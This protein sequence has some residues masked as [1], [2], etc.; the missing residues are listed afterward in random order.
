LKKRSF[1]TVGSEIS[2]SA[3]LPCMDY[4]HGDVVD[5]EFEAACYYEYAKESAFLREAARLWAS[6]KDSYKEIEKTA[7]VW[8]C[9]SFL[10]KSW[11]QLSLQE[12]ANILKGVQSSQIQPLRVIDVW[13]LDAMGI[14]DELETMAEEVM[15]SKRL[16]KPQRKVY[17]IIEGPIMG[18]PNQKSAWVHV[19]FTLDFGK[20][21]KR[22]LQEFD[23][24]LQLPEN[25]ARLDAHRQNPTGKTGEF[26]DRLKDLAAWRIYEGC[27]RDWEKADAFANDHRIN[28]RPFHD[29]RQGQTKKTP[30]NEA[31][32]YS[33]ES[34]FLKAKARALAY[35]TK[36]GIPRAFWKFTEDTEELR[37]EVAKAFRHDREQVRKISKSSS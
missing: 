21:K 30:L 25:K 27:G 9:P 23:Q 18:P 7:L 24:W 37:N 15:E 10:R 33:E 6:E 13:S 20:T 3:L 2:Q 14:F 31:S 1:K 29:P 32:L 11:N 4:L 5:N 28:C 8:Q 26:K 19:L 22:L 34:G 16:R 35:R 36:L 17:P 12:R